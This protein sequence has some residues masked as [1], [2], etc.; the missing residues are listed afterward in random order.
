MTLLLFASLAGCGDPEIFDDLPDAILGE[1]YDAQLHA[2]HAR[3]PIRYDLFDGALPDGLALD[4]TGRI[5]G[6]PVG[7]GDY[8]FEVRLLDMDGNWDVAG[9]TLT[10]TYEEHQVFV[11]PVLDAADLNGLCLDGVDA[12]SGE[13]RH[14]M[15]MPWV[16]VSGGGMAGQSERPVEAGLFWVG[17]NGSPDG[18]W[19]DDVLIR[20]LATD[21]VQWS[22]EPGEFFPQ[23]AAEGVNSPTDAEVTDGGVLV[24]GERTGPGWIQVVHAEHGAHDIDAMVVPPDFCP[25]PGGC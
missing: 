16:R 5:T 13:W 9:L 14:H 4:D 11:G 22:F 20:V 1:A 25:A 12:P 6:F 17:G 19:Y 15:C 8:T 23:E 21:E 3:E 10:V 18:G 7:A 2:R 24:A